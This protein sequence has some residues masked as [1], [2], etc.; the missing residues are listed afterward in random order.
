M[1]FYAG[2][3]FLYRVAAFLAYMHSETL[4]PVFLAILILGIHSVLQPY[5]SWKYNAIDGLIFLNIAIIN[6]ITEMIKY[7]LTT[8][9]SKNILQLKLIQLAFI[10]LPIL[11]LLLIILVRMGRKIKM[12]C[13]VESRREPPEPSNNIIITD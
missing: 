10:Y 7:S 4:P 12:V 8:E 1:R 3:Y 9:G 13:Q 5:K 6:S 11:S 2:L